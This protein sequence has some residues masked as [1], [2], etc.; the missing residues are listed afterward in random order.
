MSIK[1]ME[2][3]YAGIQPELKAASKKPASMP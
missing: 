2:D 3:S 1:K